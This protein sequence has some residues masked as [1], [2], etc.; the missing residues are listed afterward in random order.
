M[1]RTQHANPLVAGAGTVIGPDIR[2]LGRVSGEEDLH[3]QGRVDG[4]SR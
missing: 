1:A 4:P 2:V 3:V